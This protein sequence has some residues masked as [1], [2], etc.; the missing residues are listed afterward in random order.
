MSIKYKEKGG[1]NKMLKFISVIVVAVINWLLI[2]SNFSSSG[3]L[4]NFWGSLIVLILCVLLLMF[5]SYKNVDIKNAFGDV[6]SKDRRNKEGY[7]KDV[8]VMTGISKIVI[9]VGMIAFLGYILVYFTDTAR[10]IEETSRILVHSLA[11]IFYAY[12]IK[13]I[14]FIPMINTLKVKSLEIENLSKE[15]V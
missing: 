5:A 14:F 7:E 10:S 6:F 11:I 4:F 8:C 12:F 15:E 1:M 9:Q 3:N 13:L 2:I